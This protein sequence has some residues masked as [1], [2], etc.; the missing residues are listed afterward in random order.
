MVLE[1]TLY[2]YLKFVDR[3]F[4]Q[5]ISEH[6]HLGKILLEEM[7][8]GHVTIS[9]RKKSV[10]VMVA[11]LIDQVGSKPELST[12]LCTL[13]SDV[14]ALELLVTMLRTTNYRK[15]KRSSTVSASIQCMPYDTE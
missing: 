14:C 7:E 5:N 4:K 10:Q 8:D 13:C 1:K 3:I 12:L 9:S 15:E 2:S 11:Y 6:R